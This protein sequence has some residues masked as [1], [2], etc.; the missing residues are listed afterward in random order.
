MSDIQ[1]ALKIIHERSGGFK[2]RLAVMLGSGLGEV[3][4]L[5]EE[6][7]SIPYS[8][9]PGF[10]RPTVAG[11]D[12]QMRLGMVAGV[13][14]VFLKGRQHFYEGQGMGAMKVLIRTLKAWGI[15]ALCLTNA[16]GSLRAEYDVGSLV[17][18]R[19]HINFMGSNPLI[20]ENDDEWGPRFVAMDNAWDADLRTQ[21]LESIQG[22]EFTMPVGEGVYMAFAGPNF[23][24]PAEVKMASVMGADTV[25]MSTVPENLIAVHCGLKCVGVSAITNLAEGLSDEALSH[26]HTLAGAEKAAANMKLLIEVFIASLKI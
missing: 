11:H 2:P 20:G 1:N 22:A 18:I 3:D 25:G 26:E 24:T 23:E 5:L 19:D 9:L 21:L 6:L 14:V 13:P 4:G 12:G 10:P 7:V 16:A 17:V 8:N 15:E